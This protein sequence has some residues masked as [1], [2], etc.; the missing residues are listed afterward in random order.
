MPFRTVHEL[1]PPDI[2]YFHTSTWKDE[3]LKEKFCCGNFP[4]F[5]MFWAVRQ[6]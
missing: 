2:Y 6:I 5:F 1:Q 4:N 3:P